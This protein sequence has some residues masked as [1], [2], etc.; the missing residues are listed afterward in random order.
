MFPELVNKDIF[1]PLRNCG[2]FGVEFGLINISS[3]DHDSL[4]VSQL[5]GNEFAAKTI[6]P[7][8][9]GFDRDATTSISWP[10][11]AFASTTPTPT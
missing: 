5:N 8:A 2:S 9:C 4:I 7:I 1:Q 11:W 10:Y 6:G 3:Q